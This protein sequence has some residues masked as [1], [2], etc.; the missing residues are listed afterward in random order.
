MKEYNDTYMIY[1]SA[2]ARMEKINKRFYILLII[3]FIAFVGSNIFWIT[4]ESQFEEKTITQENADGINNYIGNDGD[5]SNG[6]T[7][8]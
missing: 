4:Y 1:E 7:G 2:L 3:V 8:N 6:K 5:I